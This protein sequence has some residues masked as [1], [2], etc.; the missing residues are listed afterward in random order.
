MGIG[1]ALRIQG[2]SQGGIT[3]VRLNG[4][5]NESFDPQALLSEAKGQTVILDLSGVTRLSSFGVREWTNAMR[6]LGASVSNVYWVEVSP[7]IVTQLNLVTNFSGSAQVLSV[8]APYYCD[9]GSEGEESVDLR[10]GEVTLPTPT[11][12]ECGAPMAFDED[13]DSY[14]LFP[15]E[16][17]RSK[18][19]DPNIDVFLRHLSGESSYPSSGSGPKASNR[20]ASAVSDFD[21]PVPS[22]ATQPGSTISHISTTTGSFST[23]TRI[24]SSGSRSKWSNTRSALIGLAIPVLIGVVLLAMWPSGGATAELPSS[25]RKIYEGHVEAGRWGEAALLVKNLE[26]SHAISEATA[27]KLRGQISSNAL[28]SF[29]SKLDEGAYAEAARIVTSA[30]RERAISAR[31]AGR[32]HK[33]VIGRALARH[34]ELLGTGQISAAEQISESLLAVDVL[35]TAQRR[36]FERD[37]AKDRAEV[38]SKLFAEAK[39]HYEAKRY[40]EALEV[41]KTLARLGPLDAKMTFLTAEIHRALDDVATASVHYANFIEMV[42][43]E[44][45]PHSGLDGAMY[46]HAKY[47]ASAGRTSDAEALFRKVAE[48]QGEYRDRAARALKQ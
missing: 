35:P 15:L 29:E 41:A 42:E 1:S 36:A 46:W 17:A 38:A 32:L 40:D 26:Q 25:S 27:T 33:D 19:T 14:F 47:L 18:P 23:N 34:R 16:S 13:P 48:G 7:A 44:R 43:D 39:A 12:A 37:V 10:S 3:Y 24:H 45:P 8:R 21:L 30:S 22:I 9:C 20:P 28:S 6:S 5:I 2:T 31:D 11:C 4:T